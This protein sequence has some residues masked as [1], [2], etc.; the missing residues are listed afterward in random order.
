MQSGYSTAPADWAGIH[1]WF[2]MVS[3]SVSFNSHWLWSLS[4]QLSQKVFDLGVKIQYQPRWGLRYTD[5]TPQDPP[6]KGVQNMTPVLIQ[7]ESL[8]QPFLILNTVVSSS[9]VINIVEY[10]LLCAHKFYSLIL[11]CAFF[12]KH[13]VLIQG[14][15]RSI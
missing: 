5:C 12:M 10:Q 9:S 6:K 3:F 13:H 4:H 7:K 8:T 11:G 14:V 1:P 2:S 15:L